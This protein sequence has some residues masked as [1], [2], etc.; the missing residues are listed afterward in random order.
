MEH[1]VQAVVRQV[2]FLRNIF[3]RVAQDGRGQFY[4]T[5]LVNAVYVTEGRRDGETVA[6]RVQFGVRVVNVFRL[7]V[8]CGSV[9]MAVVHA[10][11]FTAGAAQF[12]FQGHAHF[13]HALQVFGADF[14][15]LFQRLF[16]QVDHVRREQRFAGSGKVF[17][18][19]VQQAVDP[20]QQFLR[21][22]VGVQ[23]N[24]HAVMFS[25]LV[26]VMRARD[27]AQN[28]CL[29]AFAFEAFACDKRGTAVREL[30]DNRRFNFRSGFQNGVDGIGT[31][32]VNCRQRKVVLFSYL[33]YFL[34]VVAS[35]DARFYEI[36]NFRHIA[37]SCMCI[38]DR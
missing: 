16:R 7:G 20:R 32:A 18:T 4:V 26:N 2:V 24:R 5:R 9:H 27:S 38:F 23:D 13:G 15:V 33:E 37:L 30:N 10:I 8:E 31:H 28:R 35:D 22:V 36:K 3:L 11:F 29:L 1:E 25:H 21:A 17:F 6:D 14:D 19:R 12:D 34:Y